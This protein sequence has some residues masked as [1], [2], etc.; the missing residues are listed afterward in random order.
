MPQPDLERSGHF[1][2]YSFLNHPI[3]YSRFY[4]MDKFSVRDVTEL[5]RGEGIPEMLLDHFA[6]M[7]FVK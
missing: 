6:G 4:G 3:G 7:N 2:Q 5:L 1:E